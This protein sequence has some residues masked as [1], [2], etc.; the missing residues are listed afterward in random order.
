MAGN[1]GALSQVANPAEGMIPSASGGNDLVSQMMKDMLDQNKRKDTYL[2]QQQAALTRAEQAGNVADVRL[3][4]TLIQGL[5]MQ[6]PQLDTRLNKLL[7][8]QRLFARQLEQHQ[9]AA[10]TV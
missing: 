6:L 1:M 5:E 2:Q 10:A 4:L 9:A 3:C 7:Q 8:S